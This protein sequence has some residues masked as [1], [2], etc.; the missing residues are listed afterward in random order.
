MN[1]EELIAGLNEAGLGAFAEQIAALA[2][3]AISVTADLDAPVDPHG[4]KFG[5]YPSF[6]GPWPRDDKGN[7]LSFL[8]Q[9]EMV[10]LA[11]LDV[12]GLLPREGALFFFYDA[13]QEAWGFEP[14]HRSGWRVIYQT[15][16]ISVP[17]LAMV[18]LQCY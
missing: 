7:P 10:P 8:C 1:K 2:K 13:L 6:S 15:E 14:E 12:D 4:T 16:P 9:L 11:G 5:S 18:I 17:P 3:N